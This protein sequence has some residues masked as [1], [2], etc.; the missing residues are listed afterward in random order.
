MPRRLA[1][2]RKRAI[3]ALMR[4]VSPISGHLTDDCDVSSGYDAV[5]KGCRLGFNGGLSQ[6][7]CICACN[8]LYVDELIVYARFHRRLHGKWPVL[9]NCRRF[10]PTDATGATG[11][12]CAESR[13]PATPATGRLHTQVTATDLLCI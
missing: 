1:Y 13:S 3:I 9:S 2:D 8:R 4:I 6:Y 12:V 11:E 10:E 5:N 7:A